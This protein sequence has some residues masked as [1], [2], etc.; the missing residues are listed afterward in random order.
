MLLKTTNS[1]NKIRVT[2]E[3]KG[4]MNQMNVTAKGN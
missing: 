4:N 3:F 1:E 2:G